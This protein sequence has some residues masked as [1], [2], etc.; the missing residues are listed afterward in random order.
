MS[1]TISSFLRDLVMF[2][3]YELRESHGETAIGEKITGEYSLKENHRGKNITEESHKKS[4]QKVVTHIKKNFVDIIHSY[5]NVFI[6]CVAGQENHKMMTYLVAPA[7]T[8]I[9]VI[10]NRNTEYT[11]NIP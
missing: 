7:G 2:P 9:S 1:K 4:L 3:I 11:C 10:D 8:L 5:T 6:S